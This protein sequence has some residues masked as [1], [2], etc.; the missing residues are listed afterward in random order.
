MVVD[1]MVWYPMWMVQMI[2]KNRG[3]GMGLVVCDKIIT[4][5]KA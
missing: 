1:I 3:S 2:L 4:D 5:H